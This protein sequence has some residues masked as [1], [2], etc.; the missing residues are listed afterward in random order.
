MY[1]IPQDTDD[2]LS[3]LSWI[4]SH[5]NNP[6]VTFATIGDNLEGIFDPVHIKGNSSNTSIPRVNQELACGYGRCNYL[7]FN[8]YVSGVS[9][10]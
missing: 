4:I 1:A 3:L 5:T 6:R 10:I 7:Q 8:E 2:V 9:R